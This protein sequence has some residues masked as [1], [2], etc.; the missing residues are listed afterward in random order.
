MKI[1]QILVKP[2]MT[3]KATNLTKGH[4]YTFEV[5]KAASKSQVRKA[6]EK[7]YKVKTSAVRTVIKK[8]KERRVGRRMVVKRNPDR[9]IAFI[10]VT[11]GKIDLFPQT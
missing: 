9:K 3:E 6:L 7:L 5:H 8:G 11:E 2:V 10:T 4:V 1:N